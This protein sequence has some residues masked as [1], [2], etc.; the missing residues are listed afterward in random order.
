MTEPIRPRNG[1]CSRWFHPYE[2]DDTTEWWVERTEILTDMLDD[3]ERRGLIER[4][5]ARTELAP[6]WHGILVRRLAER[7]SLRYRRASYV[8]I[9]LSMLATTVAVY[10]G[11][12][13]GWLGASIGF[14]VGAT[15]ANLWRLAVLRGEDGHRRTCL[16]PGCPGCKVRS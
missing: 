3:G 9:V 11:T 2:P 1:A 16:H 4:L 6:G 13:A 14:G 12:R 7:P 5:G 15:A 10:C 8:A